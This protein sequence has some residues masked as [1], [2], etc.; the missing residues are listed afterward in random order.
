MYSYITEELPAIVEKFFHISSTKKSI[1]GHSMGGNGALNIAARNPG[2][3]KSV[4]AFA[5][6]GNSSNPESDFCGAAMKA[7]FA[8]K[9]EEA[10]KYDCSESI[11][12]AKHM[13]HGLID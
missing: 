13:P 6:I 2:M 5:P 11:K 7:Y 8:D 10:K 3:Y 9:P 12:A 4:S 1:M